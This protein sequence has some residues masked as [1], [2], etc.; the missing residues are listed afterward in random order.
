MEISVKQDAL[1]L[2]TEPPEYPMVTIKTMNRNTL[3]RCEAFQVARGMSKLR[4]E[5]E[6]CRKDPY[7]PEPRWKERRGQTLAG[8]LLVHESYSI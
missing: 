7:R 3:S 4:M 2:N 1:V 6:D 8:L 5:S